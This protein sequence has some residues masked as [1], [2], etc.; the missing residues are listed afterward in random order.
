[1]SLTIVCADDCHVS[2]LGITQLL[3]KESLGRCLAVSEYDKLL[4][5]CNS[6]SPSLIIAELRLGDVDL[7][8]NIDTLRAAAP[9]V[10]FIIYTFHENPTNIARASVCGAIDFLFKS[11]PPLLL[12][13][14]VRLFAGGHRHP[15]PMLERARMFLKQSHR[16][17]APESEN[18]TRRELQ[19][20]VHLSLG[21][22]NREIGNS[23]GISLETVKEHVQNV[24][25]KIEANDRTAAAV[26]AIRNGMPALPVLY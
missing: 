9:E 26:W 8:E 13:D 25:R 17:V 20:L 7:M 15:S 12:T 18:L 22:S 6:E 3:A 11:R 14:T 2:A 16:L 1:M 4:A 10:E 23:L 24:L 21:L 5:V 19:I